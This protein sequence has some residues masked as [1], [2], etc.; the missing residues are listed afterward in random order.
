MHAELILPVLVLGCGLSTCFAQAQSQPQRLPGDEMI[1]RYLEA[2]TAKIEARFLDG[3]KSREDWLA[4]RPRLLRE[5]FYMLGLW[6]PLPGTPLNATTTRTLNGDGYVVEMVH[7]QS[8]PQLYVTGN[9]YRPAGI[10]PGSRLPA[11]LYVCGHSPHG[12]DGNKTR[13]QSFG[14]WFARHGYVCLVIDTLQLG[15]IAGSHHG[16]YREGKWWW[17]SRGYTPAGIECWNGIR[18]L[19]Y[20]VS[21]P[22]VDAQRLAVTGISG[23]GATSFW[24]AAADERVKVAVPVSGM[25][26]LESYIGHKIVKG[27]CDCMFLHNAFMWPWTNIAALV[28][29]RPLLFV[30]SD[31]DPIFPMDANERIS[32]RLERVYSLFGAGDLMESLVSIGD[33]AYREDI[34]QAGYRFINTYL[35]NDSSRVTDSE[36]DLI[37]NERDDKTYPIAPEKLRVFP[38]DSDIPGD[39]LNVSIDRRFVPV[40]EVKPPQTGAFEAWKTE[41][42][43]ELIRVSLGFL[44]DRIPPARLLG[45]EASGILKMTS[46][47]HIEFSIRPEE[48]PTEKP[49]RIV[50]IVSDIEEK[51]GDT[52]Q[53]LTPL[54]HADDAVYL[55][56]TRG[57]GR[58]RWTRS[59]PGNDVE[60]SHL[61]IGRTVDTG[62]IWDVIAAAGYLSGEHAGRPPVHVMGRGAAGIIA[63]YAAL[64]EPD[65]AAVTV[66]DP[67]AGH[68]EPAAPQIT[69]VLRVCDIPEVLGMIAPRP[70]TIVGGPQDLLTKVTAIYTA[71]GKPAN[72]SARPGTGTR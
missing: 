59:S 68:M 36:S 42:M 1:G 4:L 54:L 7:Y 67:P 38:Q 35:K 22:D 6:P 63:A 23:G 48:T 34:R 49:A 44:P 21:R 26:D 15:E 32:N 8:R 64:W 58:T 41:L 29:P 56:E 10:T 19:D 13:F 72:L 47:E 46:E 62:R 45:H 25:S 55:C 70:L 14:I 31:T 20:L 12:R 50:L 43:T 53:W 18:G 60:R 28:A 40:A 69:N 11:V 51:A 66:I 39:Q 24:I 30:N 61:L 16:T 2:E 9:L 33:H 27:H 57:V 37:T 17:Q 52:G 5:Y 71:A 3:V 65:I